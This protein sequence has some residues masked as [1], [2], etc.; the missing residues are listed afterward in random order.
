MTPDDMI[1][2]YAY[3][4]VARLPHSMRADVRAELSALLHEDTQAVAGDGSPTNVSLERFCA[5]KRCLRQQIP[6]A[7]L[8]S[9]PMDLAR[10][11]CTYV[12]VRC[13]RTWS[14]R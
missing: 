2:R 11:S 7:A 10:Q 1:E 6:P 13:L 12:F 8:F 9:R 14:P 3:A 5:H 4:V